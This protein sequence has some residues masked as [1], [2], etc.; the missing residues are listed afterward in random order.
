MSLKAVVHKIREYFIRLTEVTKITAAHRC[1]SALPI[2]LKHMDFL[3]TFWLH[4]HGTQLFV[5]K[6]IRQSLQEMFLSLVT[7]FCVS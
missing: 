4:N 7:D 3:V 2:C 1:L 5:S 6:I